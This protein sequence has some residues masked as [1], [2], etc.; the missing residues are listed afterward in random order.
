M[1]TSD[2]NQTQTGFSGNKEGFINFSEVVK[3]PKGEIPS[4]RAQS[5]DPKMPCR[6][7]FLFLFISLTLLVYLPASFLESLFSGGTKWLQ[8]TPHP[9]PSNT[10]REKII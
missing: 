8:E 5:Q 2:R 7:I 1:G 4:D 9:Q 10:G 3:S 6:P